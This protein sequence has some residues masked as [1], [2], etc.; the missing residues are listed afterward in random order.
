MATSGQFSWP[1]AGG[2][3]WALDIK[4][5][6]HAHGAGPVVVGISQR[7]AI[8]E[9]GRCPPSGRSRRRSRSTGSPRGWNHY[10]VSQLCYGIK[11]R[12]GPPV[13]LGYVPG[14]PAKKALFRNRNGLRDNCSSEPAGLRRR[15]V[16]PAR[17]RFPFGDLMW[18]GSQRAAGG[19]LTVVRAPNWYAAG[20]A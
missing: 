5:E 8:L 2:N 9:L 19:A 6:A 3:P 15:P 10:R 14:S 18:D 7:T 13:D 1:P 20:T 4:I 16:T 11:H 17:R 12:Y